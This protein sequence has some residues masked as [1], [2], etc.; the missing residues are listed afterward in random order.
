VRRV[1]ATV[2][3]PAVWLPFLFLAWVWFFWSS[4]PPPPA[5]VVQSGAVHQ[6]DKWARR[7]TGTWCS[8]RSVSDGGGQVTVAISQGDF[9][10]PDCRLE[11]WDTRSGASLTPALWKD[12]EWE[13]LLSAPGRK[14]AGLMACL[15][16]PDGKEFLA[17]QAAW[18]A[19]R[20]RL[21]TG[22]AR[23]LDDL[24]ATVRPVEDREAANLFPERCSFS[25]DG[26]R[27]AYV[28][29]H[30]WPLYLVSESLGDG[31]AVEDVRTGA[32]LAFLPGVTDQVYIA[33]GGRT[34]V[35][36]NHQAEREGEQPRLLLWDLN[37]SARRAGLL[38]PE[39]MTLFRIENSADGRYVFARY[40]TWH[41]VGCG[42]RWWDTATGR[43][44]GAVNN[45]GET[46]LI[47]GG[48]VLV[49]HPWRVRG[50]A[51][52]EGYVLGFWDVTTGAPLGEWDLGA[53]SDG[54]GMIEDLAGCESGGYLAAEYDPDYGRTHG[55][56]RAIRDRLAK[57]SGAGSRPEPQ[58]ILLLDVTRRRQLA[59][60]PGRSA[61]FSRN[62]Q[63]LAT[64]DEAGVVRVWEVPVRQPWARILGYTAGAALACWAGLLLMGRL[65]RRCW[66][67]G[68]GGRLGRWLVWLWGDRKR[69]RWLAGVSGCVGLA[70][71]AGLWYAVA[72]D[73]SRAAMLAAY[74]EIHDGMTEDQVSALFGRPPDQGPVKEMEGRMTGW[75][76]GH[77]S[78]LRKWSRNGTEVDVWFGEDGTVRGAYISDPLGLD[79]QVAIW[80]GW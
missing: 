30:G 79:E 52:C 58:H 18:E 72:A 3:K 4:V 66:G 22:R 50:G 41:D 70:V 12:A 25:P 27:F 23:A 59:R 71:G 6:E 7:P 10:F 14:D 69:R 78:T 42:L 38:L 8:L 54:G 65:G 35:S 19:L 55:A 48:R 2:R 63:W 15:S 77:P 13:R 32:R 46:A 31:T 34:A 53:P 51:L 21:S 43:Q 20:R 61:A 64:L 62:G 40:S 16:H 80:L 1:L 56:V 68:A 36:V 39:V 24:R 33:P 26:C 45:P 5:F 37:T 49:T 75:E 76:S 57:G 17:D 11:V 60:L 29:R 28:A 44:V 74:E 67:P 47:E 73:R 9:R